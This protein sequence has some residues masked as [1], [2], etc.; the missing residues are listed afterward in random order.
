MKVTTLTV[1][2]CGNCPHIEHKPEGDTTEYG[3]Y[4][5]YSNVWIPERVNILK[6]VWSNCQLN[7]L[8]GD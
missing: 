2:I 4:C 6:E 8:T 3:Y 7:D 1:N 5:N